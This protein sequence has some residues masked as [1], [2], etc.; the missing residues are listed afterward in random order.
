[1]ATEESHT[2]GD[3]YVQT[4]ELNRREI[5]E[6]LQEAVNK[7]REHMASCP[8]SHVLSQ[9]FERKM[10]DLFREAHTQEIAF[11]LVSAGFIHDALT[12]IAEQDAVLTFL[13]S[14]QLN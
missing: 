9:E 13:F 4:I 8:E 6:T 2:D 7:W 1:M 11:L 3:R 12:S 14:Q 5:N 10:L